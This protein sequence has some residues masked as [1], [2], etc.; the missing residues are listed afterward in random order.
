MHLHC[1]PAVTT[2][3]KITE[4]EPKVEDEITED[5]EAG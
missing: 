3:E 1:I 4:D 5:D 2:E